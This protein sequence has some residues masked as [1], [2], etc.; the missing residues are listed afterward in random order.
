MVQPL[1]NGLPDQAPVRAGVSQ[2]SGKSVSRQQYLSIVNPQNAPQ[3]PCDHP[4]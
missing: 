4:D 2:H 1:R 3:T